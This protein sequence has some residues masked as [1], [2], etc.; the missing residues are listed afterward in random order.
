MPHSEDLNA[1]IGTVECLR[2]SPA[3]PARQNSCSAIDMEASSCPLEPSLRTIFISDVHLGCRHSQ[4][5]PLLRF[6]S[7]HLPRELY[8]VG[9]FLDGW[10]LERRWRWTEEY[11]RIIERLGVMAKHGTR[12]RYVPGNHDNFLRQE[13]FSRTLA[14]QLGFVEI[15]ETF[16]CTTRSG[17]KLLVIHGDQFDAVEGGAQWIS[18]VSA[19]AYDHALTANAAI[20]KLYGTTTQSP[21]A[22]CGR[23]KQ[24]VKRRV[25]EASNFHE[26]LMAFTKESGCDGVVCGHIHTPE[27]KMVDDL[28]YANSGDWVEHCTAIVEQEDGTI[29]LFNYYDNDI[30]PRRLLM[31]D[32]QTG[33]SPYEEQTATRTRAKATVPFA[34]P[35]YARGART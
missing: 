8:L 27:L 1:T 13:V 11:H 30:A 26:R 10:Q 4:A 18:R 23:W 6:L 20:S 31:Q 16:Q 24:R 14:G 22:W 2:A 28:V 35:T 15:A 5:G 3:R 7:Q 12:I 17:R 29:E 19:A 34:S 21:Y 32:L 25:C 9:D 33:E